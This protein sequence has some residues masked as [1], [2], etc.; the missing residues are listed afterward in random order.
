MLGS[1]DLFDIL[2]P[3]LA[4]G[5]IYLS[6]KRG[7]LRT[8]VS[9]FALFIAFTLAALIYN[10]FLNAFGNMIGSSGSAQDAGS[11]LFGAFTLVFYL[12]LEYMV[13]HNYP[14]LRINALG[15]WNHILGAVVGVV[16]TALAIS[17]ILLVGE[18]AGLTLGNSPAG[19]VLYTLSYLIGRST[20]AT[21]FRS[22]FGYVLVIEKLL[23]PAGLPDV[24]KYFAR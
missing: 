16:W 8:L 4:F 18:Y 10:P 15:N 6:G 23:F 22:F 1:V 17:L 21:L 19:G 12:F 5:G 7:F 20:F 3:L 9:T 2:L 14:G 13:S 11:V 24:L